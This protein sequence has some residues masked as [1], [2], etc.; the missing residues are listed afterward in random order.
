MKRKINIALFTLCLVGLLV[1]TVAGCS[2]P[3][4]IV[5]S[6]LASVGVAENGAMTVA[7]NAYA[8]GQ[9]TQAQWNQIAD[10]HSKFLPAYDTACSASAVAL[11]QA[12]VPADVT[13]LEADVVNLVASFVQPSK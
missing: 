7:A 8:K 6:T 1:A 13:T 4:K 3:A 10:A 9:I 5:Y 11:N 12:T 2:S